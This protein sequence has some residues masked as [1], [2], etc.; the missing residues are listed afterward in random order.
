MRWYQ[1]FSSY[2]FMFSEKW[3]FPYVSWATSRTCA[4]PGRF[5]RTR[6]AAW[7]KRTAA[8]FRRSQR[9]RAIRTSP[10]FSRSSSGRWWSTWSTEPTGGATVAPSPWPNWLTTCLGRGGNP[11]EDVRQTDWQETDEGSRDATETQQRR[12]LW[13]RPHPSLG[14]KSGLCIITLQTQAPLK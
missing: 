4:T 5:E 7:L 3:T 1:M 10:A 13:Q 11:C 9:L 2:A 14:T 8:T 6:P 12:G